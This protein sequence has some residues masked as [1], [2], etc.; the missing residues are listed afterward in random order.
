M[1]KV[2]F[3]NLKMKLMKLILILGL[4]LGLGL[5]LLLG[6]VIVFVKFNV[7]RGCK[8]KSFFLMPNTNEMTSLTI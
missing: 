1:L 2:K 5:I 8:N 6:L 7:L 4:G 3:F